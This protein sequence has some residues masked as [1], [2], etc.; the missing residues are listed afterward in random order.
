MIENKQCTVG[1][2]SFVTSRESPLETEHTPA[3]LLRQT[4]EVRLPDET[5]VNE[6]EIFFK[7]FF[8]E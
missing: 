5:C 2:T 8:L 1:A 3:S 4:T 7:E 6:N